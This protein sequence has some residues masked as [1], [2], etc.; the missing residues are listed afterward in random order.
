MANALAGPRDPR[1][2]H[3]CQRLILTAD[4]VSLGLSPFDG[5]EGTDPSM[6]QASASCFAWEDKLVL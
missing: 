5:A 1:P 4:L 6:D 2:G 3:R